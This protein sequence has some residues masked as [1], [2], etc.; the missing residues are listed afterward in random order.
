MPWPWSVWFI[1]TSSVE[2]L[3]HSLHCGQQRKQSCAI[4]Q[5]PWANIWEWISMQRWICM[6]WA[7]R[8]L[9]VWDTVMLFSSLGTWRQTQHLPPD[10]DCLIAAFRRNKYRHGL[11]SKPIWSQ[12]QPQYTQTLQISL[13]T[14]TFLTLVLTDIMPSLAPQCN[15]DPHS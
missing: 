4:F 2:E 6:L 13:Y 7:C 15:L 12:L 3:L 14:H 11:A 1:Y 9:C 8:W 10:V 5:K